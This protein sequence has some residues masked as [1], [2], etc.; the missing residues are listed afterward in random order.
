MK[1]N[2]LTIKHK[3]IFTVL[4]II[5]A[6]LSILV[7][8]PIFEKPEFYSKQIDS[9]SEKEDT[10]YKL[11]T[12]AAV[13]SVAI[14]AVPGESTSAIAD[15]ITDLTVFF[16]ISLSAVFLEKYIITIIGMVVFRFIVPA[17]CLL[18]A[19][20]ILSNDRILKTWAKTW[21]WR[22]IGFAIVILLAVPLSTYMADQMVAINQ[23]TIE[24]TLVEGSKDTVTDEHD[25]EA[26]KRILSSI[27]GAIDDVTQ[28]VQSAIQKAKSILNG[29]IASVAVML[30][31][32]CVMPI[33]AFV[34][35]LIATKMFFNLQF[36]VSVRKLH[37]FRRGSDHLDKIDDE[38]T[39]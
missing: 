22:A 28:G 11:T 39:V 25:D 14:S 35:V 8:S 32:T 38:V 19:I 29:F 4:L 37:S 10:L 5:I 17:A 36:D 1:T 13:S 24:Y 9:L 26:K 23:N 7:L 30:I 31:A 34:V 2:R 15:A 27:T 16:V 18:G 33:L 3:A 21:A 12:A 20:F 6:V